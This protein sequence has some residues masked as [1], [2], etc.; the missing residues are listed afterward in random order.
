MLSGF[1]WFMFLFFNLFTGL[2]WAFATARALLGQEGSSPAMLALSS[3]GTLAQE[4]SCVDLLAQR[5][6]GS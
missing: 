1:I 2:R 6:V 4:L 5:P 3:C